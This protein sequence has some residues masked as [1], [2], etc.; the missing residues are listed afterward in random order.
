[1]PVKVVR[2][3]SDA[4]KGLPAKPAPQASAAHARTAR[5]PY[6]LGAI[7]VLFTLAVFWRVQNH[8]F[9]WDDGVN[10]ERNPYFQ[11]GSLPNITRFWT[12][13]YENL[14]VPMAYTVWGAI[15]HVADLPRQ[16]DDVTKLDPWL[17]HCVN[18]IF[19]ALSAL[20]VFK[21][22][23]R[24]VS[25]DYAAAAGALLF[26]WHPVQVEAVAWITGL[27]DVLSGFFAILAIL[28]YLKYVDGSAPTAESGVKP[29]PTDSEQKR[30]SWK[31]FH[32]AVGTIA[33]LLALLAK[34]AAVVTPLIAGIFAYFLLRCSPRQLVPSLSIWLAIA[35]PIIVFTKLQQPDDL[36]DIHTRLLGRPLVAADAL[37]FY[38]Y[39][40]FF[41]IYFGPGYAR[42]PEVI[43][44][45][46]WAFISWL[47]PTSVGVAIW[48]FA[49]GKTWIVA[50]T[51][52]FVVG[53]LPVLG[54]VQFQ[55][56][57]WSTV[58]DRY[59]Y[60]SMLGPALAFS[61][62][63]A[64]HW[65]NRIWL[66]IGSAVLIYLGVKSAFQTEIWHNSETLWRYAV[67]TGQDSAVTRSNLGA[68]LISSKLAEAIAHLRRAVELAPDFPDGHYNLARA[69]A[70]R[71]DHGEAIYHYRYALK[72]RPSYPNVHYFLGLSLA[73]MGQW[74][75]AI[76]HHRLALVAS[77]RDAKIHNNL[78]NLLADRG[79]LDQA[80][81]QYREAI[82]LKPNFAGAYFNLGIV[83]QDRG[84][85]DEGKRQYLRVLQLDPN[86]SDAHNNLAAILIGQGRLEEA[87]DHF[88]EALRIKPDFVEAQRGLA[89]VTAKA[90]AK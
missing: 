5:R 9:V 76:E 51:G 74:D 12:G 3:Q 43:F 21:I 82:R 64:Q 26:A 56:Q 39:K 44:L 79:L 69:L 36:L 32:Y 66:G 28:E 55:Y 68:T 86:H 80:I 34:P 38:L 27:K 84:D 78:G 23:R 31:V 47:L 87:A 52:V 42:S 61:Y 11:S 7:I 59:L 29:P 54:L 30:F 57:N 37:A 83:F 22:L 90:K 35:A 73:K 20:L 13:S 85:L 24:F 72:L 1:M 6:L 18:L 70:E 33:F 77:P 4:A 15:A 2:F 53:L 19:H 25:N 50:A 60:L 88:R 45:E 71:G 58:S 49:R 63:V 14:Y 62:L 89:H 17:F 8:G 16:G 41:P 65:K 40:L 81:E 10:V 46:G 48:F 75:E 67:E